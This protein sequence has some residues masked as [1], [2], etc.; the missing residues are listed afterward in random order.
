MEVIDE[1]KVQSSDNDVGTAE[2][3][4]AS[5]VEIV[6]EKSPNQVKNNDFKQ[7]LQ[8]KNSSI[9]LAIFSFPQHNV[10]A[11]QAGHHKL[12]QKS[13]RVHPA[14]SKSKIITRVSIPGKHRFINTYHAGSN[15]TKL[16]LSRKFTSLKHNAFR[17]SALQL[18]N[19]INVTD[20]ARKRINQMER[21]QA[22][23]RDILEAF[24][25]RMGLNVT[26]DLHRKPSPRISV[27]EKLYHPSPFN[28]VLSNKV[29][30][31]LPPKK[32]SLQKTSTGR[33]SYRSFH[34]ARKS[35][36]L[37]D[38]SVQSPIVIKGVPLEKIEKTS[39]LK[40]NVFDS[41][42]DIKF[43][44][45]K[46]NSTLKSGKK[47][48]NN[49]TNLSILNSSL[50]DK[51]DHFLDHIGTGRDK[52]G[53]GTRPNSQELPLRP[54]VNNTQT[55]ATMTQLKNNKS[56]DKS[57]N[58]MT[59]RDKSGLGTRPNGQVLPLRPSVNNTQ[60][61][62]TMTQLKNNKNQDK[63]K[64]IMTGRDKSGLATRPN[65]EVL[66]L[67]PSVNNTQTKVTMTQQK[68]N[69]SQNKSKN[70]MTGRDKSGLGTSP[71]SQVLHLRPS[72]NNTQTKATMT[73]QRINKS[74]NKSK[75][76][77]TGRDKSGLGTS[78]NS[79]VLHL[80][81][82][83]NNTQTK[84]T[85]TQQ[86][87]N[88]SQNKSKNIM[89]GRDKSGL[90][91]SPNSQ[92]LHLR[93]SVNNTQTKATM[94]QQRINKSQNKSKNIMTGRDK[95]GLGTS[96]N[97]QV[98]HLR[99]SVNNTQ[100][101]ATMTQ[102]R[103]NKSQDKSKNI[104]T[105]R[106]K[107]GLG[108]RSNSHVSPLRP[109][110]N[111]T[112]TKAT[113]PQLKENKSQNKSGNIR[114]YPKIETNDKNLVNHSKSG[115]HNLA[116][117]H[118]RKNATYLNSTKLSMKTNGTFTLSLDSKISLKHFSDLIDFF[119]SLNS[120]SDKTPTT[121]IST[122]GNRHISSKLKNNTRNHIISENLLRF[123][124]FV[125]IKKTS[126]NYTGKRLEPEKG[127][128]H[129]NHDSIADQIRKQLQM[130]IY[131]GW[132]KASKGRRL[133][134][135]KLST[136]SNPSIK[137]KLTHSNDTTR[138][139]SND[140]LKE[141]KGDDF[142]LKV[143]QMMKNVSHKELLKLEDDI[144]NALSSAR[145]WNL[146]QQHEKQHLGQ[147]HQSS[148]ENLRGKH[149]QI[150]N[151]QHD[152]QEHL[153]EKQLS[154]RQQL[155]QQ[156]QKLGMFQHHN[157][158]VGQQHNQTHTERKH[159]QTSQQIEDRNNGT[160]LQQHKPGFESEQ[161]HLQQTN[162]TK[163]HL[164]KNNMSYS[165]E[166]TTTVQNCNSS[167]SENTTKKFR[168]HVCDQTH[169]KL[170]PHNN[171]SKDLFSHSFNTSHT[172]TDALI[173]IA[174]TLHN[175][176][177]VQSPLARHSSARKI[178]E[179]NTSPSRIGDGTTV[180]KPGF[181]VGKDVDDTRNISVQLDRDSAQ[182]PVNAESVSEGTTGSA[183]EE[184]TEYVDQGRLQEK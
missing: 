58:I 36:S 155:N 46:K 129:S 72:V 133:G 22:S 70:I 38:S 34:F 147:Q 136:S 145:L 41:L 80:R 32:T 18:S 7:P 139:R 67:R 180:T 6:K 166:S 65:S 111:N 68:I 91:T 167:V 37:S 74:Q 158:K 62:A 179:N 5:L 57:K 71:N 141:S 88:K 159:N 15:W 144:V 55:K 73:Q 35:S 75:N 169:N 14:S 21:D 26:S 97:S 108:T 64:H 33:G 51:D 106:D 134:S 11:L 81:P 16:L 1:N 63:S 100:T 98:L 102:Q 99:P 31:Y 30:T 119:N 151:R 137:N 95:S 154:Y 90:G 123:L 182:E 89:T 13:T 170:S 24:I 4:S 19:N 162:H 49:S 77:M 161:S 146:P 153:S 126:G 124:N 183:V 48:G 53:V 103:I 82:S 27:K 172:K 178:A 115:S 52:S 142:E 96:P 94:T 118:A 66:H 157:P 87:I 112:Q 105:G 174:H 101:K 78:P 54:S 47:Y 23:S 43:L 138:F 61:K 156:Q 135:K 165:M 121:N 86:K 122:G 9:S 181:N 150:I 50:R 152:I 69:K 2:P 114:D 128:T 85:M 76:I 127:H 125:H 140:S 143:L 173:K 164:M 20:E 79:Q 12:K 8:T 39:P 130:S 132:N 107:S 17:E 29:N 163:Q 116:L 120:S 92:V 40:P 42:S 3:V 175:A 160:T 59:G 56:Q 168:N 25:S 184:L 171:G 131:R 149:K 109:S 113:T 10:H 44:N 28:N 60:T 84:V 117:V 93:P 176:A 83:V 148:P 104:M 45:S 110:V 177:P